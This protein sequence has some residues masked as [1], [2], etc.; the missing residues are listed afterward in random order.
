MQNII[1]LC[2]KANRDIY[3]LIQNGLGENDFLSKA[4]GIGGDISI[5]IDIKA[6]NIFISY[7]LPFGTI[8]S[9]ECGEVKSNT[10]SY[11]II[12]P[13]DGSNNIKSFFPYYGSSVFYHNKENN[14][15]FAIVCNYANG[16]L[17][18][19]KDDILYK[20]NLLLL[21]FKKV[22]NNTHSNIGIF[23]K[24]F[25]FL[26]IVE[27]LRNS[28][29]KFRSPGAVALSFAYAHNVD[30]V[31]YK[32]QYRTYDIKAGLYMC[33]DLYVEQND[34]TIIVSKDEK[35]MKQLK[36]IIGS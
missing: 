4:V 5:G 6:E 29:L 16:D 32:G 18:L 20:G 3:K 12:D 34:D 35:I 10:E 9:E 25:N 30:F 22:I 1:D 2:I 13:I 8:Y 24:A 21:N 27:Q 28:M 7:L 11:F 31:L 14:K 23:E 26:E 17:F 33:Q 36:K 19:K 15:K